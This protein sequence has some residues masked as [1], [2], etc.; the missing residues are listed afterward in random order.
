M[1]LVVLIDVVEPCIGIGFEILFRNE[2]GWIEVVCRSCRI[3]NWPDGWAFVRNGQPDSA[4]V[5]GYKVE[6][7]TGDAVACQYLYG[8]TIV[9]F[10]LRRVV[11][12][13]SSHK[14]NTTSARSS[15]VGDDRLV[16]RDRALSWYAN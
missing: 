12:G 2:L 5:E 16:A 14:Q 4:R 9:D 8:R 10:A 7:I 13:P 11:R 3:V 15:R 6:L 1:A